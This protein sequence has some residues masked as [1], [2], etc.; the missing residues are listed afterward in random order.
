MTTNEFFK[1]LNEAMDRHPII[2]RS[3]VK[4][5]NELLYVL[6][7]EFNEDF[8]VSINEKDG[9]WGCIP[10]TKECFIPVKTLALKIK[11]IVY[12][13]VNDEDAGCVHCLTINTK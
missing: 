3:K 2:K 9:T 4:T 8:N 11:G 13:E 1:A 10:S 7:M 12:E 6:R 5:I